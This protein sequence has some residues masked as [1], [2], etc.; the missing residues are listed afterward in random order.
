[1]IITT[2]FKLCFY[3]NSVLWFYN[4]YRYLKVVSGLINYGKCKKL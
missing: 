3:Y 2:V 4:L 1:M